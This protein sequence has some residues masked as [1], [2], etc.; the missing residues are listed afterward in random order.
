MNMNKRINI[1]ERF[2]RW[3]V[4]AQAR[5]D[6]RSHKK[7]LC[8][9]DCGTKKVVYQYNLNSHASCS[10]GCLKDELTIMR[11]TIH[12]YGTRQGRSPEYRVWIEIRQRCENKDNKHYKNYGGRGIKV[13]ESWRRSFTIFL[14]YLQNTIGLRPSPDHS[15]DRIDNNGNYEPWNVRWA[16]YKEQ[17]RNT[18]RTIK[19]NGMSLIDFAKK[20]DIEYGT[21]RSRYHHGDRGEKLVR[22][23]ES[24]YV[25]EKKQ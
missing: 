22:L 6:Q 15:I 2:G 9:C 4:I 12:G 5:S 16:T 7:W 10:C 1:G 11:S 20:H 23:V 17:S 3:T 18:R 25:K 13:C 8:R 21:I 14:S 24:K 19:I